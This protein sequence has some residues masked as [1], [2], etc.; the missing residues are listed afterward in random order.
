MACFCFPQASRHAL[1]PELSCPNFSLSPQ[2]E[3]VFNLY[4]V[5][6]YCFSGELQINNKQTLW[7]S[8]TLLR[9]FILPLCLERDLTVPW[10][11]LCSHLNLMVFILFSVLPEF[12]SI[13]AAVVFYLNITFKW[14]NPSIFQRLQKKKS[15]SLR[16]KPFKV[17]HSLI[18]LFSIINQ[19]LADFHGFSENSALDSKLSFTRVAVIILGN[20]NIHTDMYFR[21][22]SVFPFLHSLISNNIFLKTS[23]R[24][25][26]HNHL[27]NNYHHQKHSPLKQLKCKN[28]SFQNYF[29]PFSFP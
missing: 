21:W 19:S 22:H 11:H 23:S 2:S 18:F 17:N 14:L 25:L 12:H 16:I 10:I 3:P 8:E 24:T 20:F 7:H 5:T 26:F 15:V 28:L 13:W 27:Q 4:I 29:F 6:C 9:M 1:W